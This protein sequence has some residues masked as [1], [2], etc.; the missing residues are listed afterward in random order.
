[1]E[2]YLVA[3]NVKPLLRDAVGQLLVVK[4]ENP[5]V[6]LER[7]F[8]QRAG[9]GGTRKLFDV[10]VASVAPI[11]PAESF[12]E[13]YVDMVTYLK[14]D[15]KEYADRKKDANA[16]QTNRFKWAQG[17][18]ETYVNM[19]RVMGHKDDDIQ[20]CCDG[21]RPLNFSGAE[22][23]AAFCESLGKLSKDLEAEMGWTNVRFCQQGSSVAGYSS[24]QF[25]GKKDKPS[26]I[27]NPTS[28]DVD[29]IIHG[30]GVGEFVK[31]SLEEEKCKCWDRKGPYETR[32][33]HPLYGFK[34][35][36]AI[37]PAIAGWVDHWEKEFGGGVQLTFAEHAN[38]GF[39]PWQRPIPLA[40]PY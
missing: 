31:R 5:S 32:G 39:Y 38:P 16:I 14:K 4:P 2:A 26:R 23:H 30:D 7:F 8:E 6:F 12:K 34:D 27:T 25:K 21:V 40:S 19:L 36:K 20:S 29:V 13:K 35:V 17:N 18:K 15:D 11:D 1:M 24:N 37:S 22:Q 33:D 9:R 28:S 3:K 10:K